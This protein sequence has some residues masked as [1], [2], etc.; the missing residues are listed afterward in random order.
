MDEHLKSFSTKTASSGR[1]ALPNSKKANP[2]DFENGSIIRILAN[3]GTGG[4]VGF[5]RHPLACNRPSG[6]RA[7]RHKWQLDVVSRYPAI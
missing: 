4:R 6:K 1:S 7:V 3:E 5:C 2:R